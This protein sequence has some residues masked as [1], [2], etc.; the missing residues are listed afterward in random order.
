MLH[1]KKLREQDVIP[2]EKGRL[3]EGLVTMFLYLKGGY[4][5][6]EDFFFTRNHM[7]KTWVM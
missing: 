2:L 4:K 1:E 6:D 7:G 3:R 5:K